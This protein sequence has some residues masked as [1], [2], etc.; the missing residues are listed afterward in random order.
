MRLTNLTRLLRRQDGIALVMAIGILGVLT[1]SGTTL[2][3][4][5][6]TNARSAE[7]SQDNSSAYD[8]AEAGIN[9]MAAILH[10]PENN[11][12]NPA[13]LPSTTH[14]YDAGSFTWNGTLDN[15]IGAA[16]WTLTSTGRIKNPTGPGSRDVTRTLTAK[17]PVYP[18]LTQPLNNP[19]WNYI[20]S[21]G[22]GQT[23]DMT[24]DNTVGIKTRLFV[25]GNLC[26]NN[27]G[28]IEGGSNV[29]VIVQGQVTHKTN[30]TYIGTSTTPVSDIYVG[31]GCKYNGASS[32]RLPCRGGAATAGDV[33]WSSSYSS[34][35]PPPLVK[36]PTS[37]Q[38]LTQPVADWE[39]WYENASPGPKY[40]CQT[41]S[42]SPPAWE[43]A[44]NTAMDVEHPRHVQPDAGER[45]CL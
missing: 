9:E 11:A 2:V 8:L 20:Y 17:V 19:S 26:L 34:L 31:G 10:K 41:T 14:T 38:A 37:G 21:W 16:K 28:H 44:G 12:L 43:S 18:T 40:P 6:N 4:Y 30:Q 45:L 5:S 22:T 39:A 15:T 29:G 32:F 27:Q 13:L 24:I 1:I 3:Y 7:F 42:G 23:C 33:I 35:G 25:A 36:Q